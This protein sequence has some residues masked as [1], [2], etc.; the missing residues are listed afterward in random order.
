MGNALLG[1]DYGTGKWN[2]SFFGHITQ[3]WSLQPWYFPD[4][5]RIALPTHYN[6]AMEEI[7]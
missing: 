6:T 3:P 4:V 5:Y 2:H 1:K 7:S